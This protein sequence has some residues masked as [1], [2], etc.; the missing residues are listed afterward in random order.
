M[1]NPT[2]PYTTPPHPIDS[3][4]YVV[5]WNCGSVIQ[6]TALVR[7][8]SYEDWVGDYLSRKTIAIN[9]AQ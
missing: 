6:K 4:F 2:L 9:I 7:R 3:L 8:F 5:V 1:Q